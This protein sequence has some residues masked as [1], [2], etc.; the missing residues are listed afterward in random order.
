[1]TRIN[2]VHP[3]ELTQKHLVAEYRELPRMFGLMRDRYNKGQFPDQIKRPGQYV[4]GTGHMLFFIDKGLW[5]VNRQTALI[6]EMIDRGYSPQHLNPKSLIEGL[7]HQY[8]QDW[9]VSFEAVALNRRRLAERLGLTY[10][11]YQSTLVLAA[12][13]KA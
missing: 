5:L 9:Q 2:V 12:S 7:P 8:L 6:I 10:S 13:P 11:E 3:S 4:L 1:M